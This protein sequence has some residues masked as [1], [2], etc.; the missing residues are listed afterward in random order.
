MAYPKRGSS[1]FLSQ[2]KNKNKNRVNSDIRSPQVRLIDDD[3]TQLGIKPI[4]EALKLAGTKGLDLVEVAPNGKPPVCKILAYSKFKYEQEKKARESRKHQKAGLLKEV[5]FS[6]TIGTHDL[7]VKLKHA[8]DF[9]QAHDK[10]RFTVMF[11]GRQNK[12]ADIGLKLLEMVQKML[13]DVAT[14]EAKPVKDRNRMS[15]TLA[16]RR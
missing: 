12:H 16:P 10:V 14:L 7:E 6:P 4:S 9:L 8:K 1:D 5:R 15:M 11:R 3:G 13:E 2:N